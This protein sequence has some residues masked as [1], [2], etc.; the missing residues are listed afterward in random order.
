MPR[1]ISAFVAALAVLACA[2]PAHAV[3]PFRYGP[4]KIAWGTVSAASCLRLNTA[5]AVVTSRCDVDKRTSWIFTET[6]NGR[7]VVIQNTVT[8]TCLAPAVNGSGLVDVVCDRR[9]IA[10]QWQVYS[11][12]HGATMSL[13]N[14]PDSASPTCLTFYLVDGQSIRSARVQPCSTSASVNIAQSLTMIPTK[15]AKPN[16]L[17]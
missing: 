16:P 4:Y 12:D 11:R 14:S 3:A 6:I 8:E 9:S 13:R 17:P 15:A 7:Y 5:S 10:Q 1:W 2:T